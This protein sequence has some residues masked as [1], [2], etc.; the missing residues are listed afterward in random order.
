MVFLVESDLSLTRSRT[1]L[2]VLGLYENNPVNMMPYF[3]ET[4]YESELYSG[5]SADFDAKFREPNWNRRM[6]SF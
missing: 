6:F 4:H 2:Y 1:S 3:F 5:E